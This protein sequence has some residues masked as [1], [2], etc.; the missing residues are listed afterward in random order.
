MVRRKANGDD[1]LNGLTGLA[2][3]ILPG[4]EGAS[5]PARELVRAGPAPGDVMRVLPTR[6]E[7]ATINQLA[8]TAHRAGIANH[9]AA[10]AAMVLH[11]AHELGVPPALALNEF[12]FIRGKIGVPARILDA[13]IRRRGLGEIRVVETTNEHAVVTAFRGDLPSEHIGSR[14]TPMSFRYGIEDA[15][16]AGLVKPASAW[17]KWP[18]AMCVSKARAAAAGALFPEA[19]MGGI[20]APD[21]LGEVV[22]PNG[23]IIDVP[24]DEPELPAG[25]K[26]L[27]PTDVPAAVTEAMP[28]QELSLPIVPTTGPTSAESAPT[29]QEA[30]DRAADDLQCFRD[31]GRVRTPDEGMKIAEQIDEL[32]RAMSINDTEWDGMLGRLNYKLMTGMPVEVLTELLGHLNTIEELRKLRRAIDLPLEKWGGALAR[33]GCVSDL[34]LSPDQATELRVKLQQVAAQLE[35]APKK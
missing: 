8:N 27:A 24:L 23:E 6:A 16:R 2:G 15:Q 33:R 28:P 11:F 10:S 5:P 7:L 12:T 19:L 3:D 30:A 4:E 21:D 13:V 9:T 29:A 34:Y 25:V 18:A 35:I 22:D 20:C 31:V 26:K 32:R 17:E 1:G 14:A